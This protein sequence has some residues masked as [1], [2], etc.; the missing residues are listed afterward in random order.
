M[1]NMMGAELFE[2]EWIKGDSSLFSLLHLSTIRCGTGSGAVFDMAIEA[3][4]GKD[5]FQDVGLNAI[6]GFFAASLFTIV[7][8]DSYVFCINILPDVILD[9]MCYYLNEYY[10][11]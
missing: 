4:R 3:Q 9:F 8:V 5:G 11:M 2:L 6:K 7:P 1:I 10:F